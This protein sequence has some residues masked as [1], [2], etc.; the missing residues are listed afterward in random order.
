MSGFDESAS[1][2]FKDKNIKKLILEK[3]FEQHINVLF[4]P[5]QMMK[6]LRSASFTVRIS[7]KLCVSVGGLPTIRS[8]EVHLS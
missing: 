5:T 4:F 8:A 2:T 1:E 3:C 7:M 6:C